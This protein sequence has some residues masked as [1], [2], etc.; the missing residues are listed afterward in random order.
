MSAK[1]TFLYCAILL[2]LPF[3]LFGQDV[4]ET[5]KKSSKTEEVALNATTIFNNFLNFSGDDVSLIPYHFSYKSIKE[6]GKAFRLGAGLRLNTTKG[7]AFSTD[8][9]SD[10]LK[11]RNALIDLRLGFEKQRK[12][13]DR[14]LFY[15][16]MDFILGLD[17]FR[18]ESDNNDFTSKRRNFRT[19]L[20]PVLGLQFMFSERIGLFT[21][22]T[23]YFIR[24]D[25]KSEFDNG[26]SS[27][28]S[29]KSSSNDLSYVL[30]SNIFF[31]FRF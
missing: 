16:G 4:S 27:T 21:E 26:G 19:G 23:L 28:D 24:Q 6:N 13:T 3:G 14:W 7:E 29:E 8:F 31:F 5:I 1:N 9:F 22:S 11:T 15:T 10:D 2:S 25:V 12:I 17:H 30:P 20:G 18:F